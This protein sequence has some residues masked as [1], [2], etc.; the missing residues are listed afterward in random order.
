MDMFIFK[1]FKNSEM[2]K[3]EKKKSIVDT[4]VNRILTQLHSEWLRQEL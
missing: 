3:Y 2:L 1:H 4:V